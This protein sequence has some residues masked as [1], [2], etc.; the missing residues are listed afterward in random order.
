MDYFSIYCAQLYEQ[1]LLWY[2]LVWKQTAKELPMEEF[3][4]L[5]SSPWNSAFNPDFTRI[6]QQMN[7][8][9]TDYW[10]S[11]S[12]NTYLNK[13]QLFGPTTGLC[14]TKVLLM[15]AKCIE[16][17]IWN[18]PNGVPKITHGYTFTGEITFS[19]AV[20]A[21][22]EV[23]FKNS[24]SNKKGKF[25]ESKG[26]EDESKGIK[27]NQNPLSNALNFKVAHVGRLYVKPKDG[28]RQIKVT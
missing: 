15:G 23:A 8:P 17:D 7:K 6:Y 28:V 3:I 25:D 1:L 10:I 2:N 14:Y 19:E 16:L 13:D 5:L 11:S 27:S 9:M 20:Y 26:I 22:N 18:G 4:L 21:I 12:H 24:K